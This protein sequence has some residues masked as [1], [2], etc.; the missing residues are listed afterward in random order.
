MLCQ[1]HDI[2]NARWELLHAVSQV[3]SRLH[4][5]ARQ[6]TLLSCWSLSQDA[7]RRHGAG[8]LPRMLSANET[9][10]AMSKAGW[11]LRVLPVDRWQV[12]CMHCQARAGGEG[13]V[14][15]TGCAN[16]AHT[17]CLPNPQWDLPDSAWLCPECV[18]GLG[19]PA[20]SRWLPSGPAAQGLDEQV[21]M[22]FV[23]RILSHRQRRK[24]R[25]RHEQ[26]R[27]FGGRFNRIIEQRSQDDIKERHHHQRKQRGCR[28][29]RRQEGQPAASL[30]PFVV[31]F[32]FSHCLLY[33]NRRRGETTQV[34]N[35]LCSNRQCMV[36]R[37]MV[38]ITIV[39]LI[40]L[41]I[42]HLLQGKSVALF[43]P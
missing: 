41:P 10:D 17:H 19:D 13:M 21:N 43:K 32:E 38:R 3:M 8:A 6:H 14:F 37:N 20:L 1:D 7:S 23:Q 18:E 34:L 27:H 33:A 9:P 28:H 42:P 25:N 4:P 30:P 24:H 15:C 11:S 35:H 2:P 26:P 36:I 39:N 40:I 12:T 31:V 5:S 16:R 22:A 29:H